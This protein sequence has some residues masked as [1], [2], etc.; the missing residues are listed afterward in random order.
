MRQT[1]V[2]ASFKFMR[3]TGLGSLRTASILIG[4]VPPD[5]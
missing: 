2:Y 3:Q 4:P 1:E 5:A